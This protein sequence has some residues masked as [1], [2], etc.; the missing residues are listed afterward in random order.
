MDVE[1]IMAAQLHS[2]LTVQQA[3]S[4]PLVAADSTMQQCK[5]IGCG[6]WFKA[7]SGRQYC[8]DPEC[9]YLVKLDRS[10]ANNARRKARGVV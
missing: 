9:Q 8:L 10:R 4:S 2:S 6:Q 3:L 7:G 1:R 5:R